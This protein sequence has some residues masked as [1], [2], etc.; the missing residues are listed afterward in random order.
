MHEIV[1]AEVGEFCRERFKQMFKE[2]LDA[3]KID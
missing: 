3:K 1:K 2:Y